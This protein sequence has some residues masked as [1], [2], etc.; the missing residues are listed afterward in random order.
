MKTVL[1]LTDEDTRLDI[2]NPG[3]K[4]HFSR[5]DMVFDATGASRLL[6]ELKEKQE[7][8]LLSGYDDSDGVYALE[9][10][11]DNLYSAVIRMLSGDVQ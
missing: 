9:S 3:S 11:L 5:Y 4:R 10:S 6:K 7:R 8:G 1:I 2:V